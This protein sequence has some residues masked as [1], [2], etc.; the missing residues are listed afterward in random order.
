MLKK[1]I[2]T[3][4]KQ[5]WVPLEIDLA[6]NRN[7]RERSPKLHSHREKNGEFIFYF[8]FLTIK[9]CEKI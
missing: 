5:K 6:K 3:V 1:I 9:N 7:K 4:N 2:L 8:I